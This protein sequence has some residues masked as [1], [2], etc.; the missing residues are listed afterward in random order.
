[1]RVRERADHSAQELDDLRRWLQAAYDDGPWRPQH[2]DDIGPGPHI[3]AEDDEGELI[4]H[5]CIA[6]VPIEVGGKTVPTG[7]LVDVATRADVRGS[8]HGSAVVAAA[9]RLIESEASIG[10]L[11]TGSQSFYERL[12]W[13]RW[14]G[15][16]AVREPDGTITPTPDEDGAIMA[17]RF[18]HTPAWVSEEQPIVRPR[19]DPFEAW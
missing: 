2:W 15:R 12:G 1:V 7:Y 8:G 4:A 19:R 18:E 16:S 17:L 13:V 10:F 14:R 11:A 5:A 6:W 9:Q 3:L